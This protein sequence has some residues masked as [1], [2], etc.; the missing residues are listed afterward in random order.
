M[1]RRGSGSSPSQVAS[2]VRSLRGGSKE[3]QPLSHARRRAAPTSRCG[4]AV[5]PNGS[6]R[7]TSSSVRSSPAARGS[8]PAELVKEFKQC[9]DQVPAEPF[10]AV[11]KV[12]EEDLGVPP[13]GSSSR[14]SSARRSLPRRSPRFT[15]RRCTPES[16][17]VVKVQRPSVARARA[18]GPEGDGVARARTSS[19]GF[20]IASLANP[21]A[22]VELF[23]E[24]IVEEL[25]F[26]MEAAN[27]IDIAA[28]LARPGADRL[29][30][31]SPAPFAGHPPRAGDGAHRRV[32]L[33]RRRRHEGCRR[34]HRGSRANGDGRPHRRGDG[35]RRLPRRPARRQPV[36][37]AR[38]PHRAARLRHRRPADSAIGGWPSCG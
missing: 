33:R 19:A 27:M 5:R 38:R 3:T 17:V 11:R 24:T 22:L 4:F 2:S 18:Q 37:A 15:R 28:M 32:Q 9:R 25:D 31:A 10:E 34:R 13:R 36:R 21:P 7:P 1:F 12:V 20:P 35:V 14:S 23:A 26:R 30:R 8:V 6:A 29:R 16:S